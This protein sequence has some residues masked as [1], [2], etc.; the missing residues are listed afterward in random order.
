MGKRA[1][2][3]MANIIVKIVLLSFL[4][5]GCVTSGSFCKIAKPIRLTEQTIDQLTDREVEQALSHNLKGQKL[6]GWRP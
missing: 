4:L 1:L 5:S 2:I 6:C 3:G